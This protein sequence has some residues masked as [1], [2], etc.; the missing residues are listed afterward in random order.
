MD[1]RNYKFKIL[2]CRKEITNNNIVASLAKQRFVEQIINIYAKPE[3]FKEDLAQD[4]YIQLLEDKKTV[5]LY[6]SKQLS[7][8]IVK[9]VKLNLFSNTSRYYYKYKK[10]TENCDE[11]QDEK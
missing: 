5:E 9:M 11:I 7:Y 4:I 10:F 2:D 8:Y 6:L 1:Y 3:D